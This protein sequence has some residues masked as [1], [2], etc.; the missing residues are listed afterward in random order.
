MDTSRF[1]FYGGLAKLTVGV[2][3]LLFIP[4]G[5]NSFAQPALRAEPVGAESIIDRCWSISKED[6]SSGVTARLRNGYLTTAL[7]LEEEII[8]H[9]RYLSNGPELD[10]EFLRKKMKDLRFLYGRFYWDLGNENQA[11]LPWCGT[12]NKVTHNLKLARL[13]ERIL[14]D[15]I[16]LRNWFRK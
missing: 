12:E 13:Y 11:C 4:F 2:F 9:A 8:R 7:C 3:V 16:G 15:V 1:Y 14:R 5:G 6:W 10:V